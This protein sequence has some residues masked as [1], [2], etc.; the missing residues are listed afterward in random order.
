MERER[1]FWR[2]HYEEYMAAYPEQFVAIKDDRVF[3]TDVELGS[4]LDRI[5]AAGLKPWDTWVRFFSNEPLIL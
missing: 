1:A 4:L 5:E 2:C 3:M